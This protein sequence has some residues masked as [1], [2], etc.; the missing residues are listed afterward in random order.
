MET[1]R[2]REVGEFQV[3]RL[4]KKNRDYVRNIDDPNI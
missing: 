4:D 2:I 3:A 1:N